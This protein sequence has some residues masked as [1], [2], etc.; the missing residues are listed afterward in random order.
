MS[1]LKTALGAEQQARVKLLV[2]ALRSGE[3]QQ[4]R[5]R[6][7]DR[8]A[9]CCLGVACEV[10]RRTTGDGEWKGQARGEWFRADGE[11][12]S[13]YTLPWVVLDWYGF[14]DVNPTVRLDDEGFPAATLNDERALDFPTIADAFERTYLPPSAVALPDD[15]TQEGEKP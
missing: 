11:S 3:F 6:L 12:A 5:N 1:I 4:A 7:R 2:A 14:D 10:Y 9:Y 13:N 15:G 8:D